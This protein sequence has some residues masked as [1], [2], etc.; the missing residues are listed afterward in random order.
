MAQGCAVA[1]IPIR[2]P[3]ELGHFDFAAAG[4][5][6]RFHYVNRCRDNLFP[7]AIA[8]NYCDPLLRGSRW[9]CFRHSSAN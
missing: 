2:A 1:Q 7:D 5:R 3:I 9:I 4:N 6:S 8:G